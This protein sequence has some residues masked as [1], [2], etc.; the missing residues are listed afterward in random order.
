MATI[1]FGFFDRKDLSK[2]FKD[3]YEKISKLF[4]EKEKEEEEKTKG[5]NA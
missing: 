1:F 5:K 3:F 2:L 4:V